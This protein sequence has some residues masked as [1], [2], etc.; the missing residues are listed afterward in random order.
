MRSERAF[1]AALRAFF[2]TRADVLVP[3]GDDAAVVR[4]P[5]RPLVL[6]IDP[7]VEGVHFA[8]DAPATRV[9][10]KAVNRALSDLAAMGAIPDWLLLSVSLPRSCTPA[11]RAALFRGMRAA[12]LAAGAVVV[13]GHSGGTPGPLAID[14]V[15]VGHLPARALLRSGAR[16]GDRLHVTGPLGGS[17]LGRHF[18]FTPRL[19]EG[20][21]L[22]RRREVRACMDVSDGLLLDLAT[23]LRASGGLGAV[24]HAER[25]PIA[26]AAHWLAR[27]TG[28]SALSHALGD[29]EDFELLFATRGELGRGG[30]LTYAARVPIGEVV[31]RPGLWLQMADGRR[32]RVAPEGF[33]HAL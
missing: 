20:L 33:Q 22:T 5:R 25:I 32:H 31:A 14:V 26:R 6:K 1:T 9:G 30:P 18:T 28:K 29:G 21:W 10:R 23:L 4:A 24:L 11:R 17:R 13:G 8:A 19:R 7:V 2:P 27:Q 15:A 16:P 3:I 12:A